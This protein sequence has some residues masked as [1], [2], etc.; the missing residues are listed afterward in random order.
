[1]TNRSFLAVTAIA[2]GVF[3]AGCNQNAP[4]TATAASA[5]VAA[6]GAITH[7][8]TGLETARGSFVGLSG[9]ETSGHG[10]VFWDGNH[11]VIALASDFSFDGAPDPKVGFGNNGQFDTGTTIGPLTSDT[12]TSTY[13]VPDHI[14]VGDYSQIFIWCEEFSVPLG[15]ADLTLL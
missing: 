8:V 4:S 15:V 2:A 13:I 3:L 12:G 11:W 1:M 14:D 5:A 9:H 10:S 6:P 7:A